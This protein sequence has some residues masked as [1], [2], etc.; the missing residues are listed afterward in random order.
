MLACLLTWYWQRISCF[1]SFFF[2]LIPR[3]E[4]SR[5]RK[6]ATF[7]VSHRLKKYKLLLPFLILE[8]LKSKY[9]KFFV[10]HSASISKFK[11]F[12]QP[13]GVAHFVVWWGISISSICLHIS[14]IIFGWMVGS[15][16][17]RVHQKWCYQWKI[18]KYQ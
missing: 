9:D 8:I 5:I 10:R 6:S 14:A 12:K 11:W 1:F 4:C 16:D 17:Q 13:W 2:C 3:L 7:L 18:N 15:V